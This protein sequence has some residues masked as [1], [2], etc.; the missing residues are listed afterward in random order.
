VIACIFS[1]DHDGLVFVELLW[2]F[3]RIGRLGWLG[4]RGDIHEVGQEQHTGINISVQ[5]FLDTVQQSIVLL[6][7]H[8]TLTSTRKE[9]QHQSRN[10]TCRVDR[11]TATAKDGSFWCK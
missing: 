9:Q 7:H 6:V 10:H 4:W 3:H 8:D 2:D 11:H 1:Q 5:S